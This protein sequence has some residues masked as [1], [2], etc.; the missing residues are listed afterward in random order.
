MLTSSSLALCVWQ[1]IRFFAISKAK[2]YS[3][4]WPWCR[5]TDQIMRG[6]HCK[7]GQQ[8]QVADTPLS[9]LPPLSCDACV[10]QVVESSSPSSSSTSPC[11][12]SSEAGSTSD[13]EAERAAAPSTCSDKKAEAATRRPRTQL[14]KDLDEVSQYST[15]P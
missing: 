15:P 13:D 11:S 10:D 5:R 12:R 14:G 2:V 4:P 7:H 8:Q 6:S 1:V 3:L 9:C